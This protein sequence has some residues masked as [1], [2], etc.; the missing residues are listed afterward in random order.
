M[1]DLSLIVESYDRIQ[2]TARMTGVSSGYKRSSHRLPRNSRTLIYSSSESSSEADD[3]KSPIRRRFS[4]KSSTETLKP[5]PFAERNNT[6]SSIIEVVDISPPAPSCSPSPEIV[7]P[8]TNDCSSAPRSFPPTPQVPASAEHS[9]KVC[10]PPNSDTA[11]LTKQNQPPEYSEKEHLGQAEQQKT[12]DPSVASIPTAVGSPI[13]AEKP[14]QSEDRDV[15]Q[16]DNDACSVTTYATSSS[17]A[18]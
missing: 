15:K 6:R 9:I 11:K 3:N 13:V 14:K 16:K 4:P 18:T 2:R 1:K 12:T 10:I 8:T 5:A 17:N 7:V